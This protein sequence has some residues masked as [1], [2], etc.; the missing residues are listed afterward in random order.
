MLAQRI[1]LAALDS[2]PEAGNINMLMVTLLSGYDI[3]IAS[4]M[5]MTNFVHTPVDWRSGAVKAL[6][7]Q[8]PPQQ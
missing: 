3:G 5:N 4:S 7:L 8:A 6:Q 2:Y 1:A